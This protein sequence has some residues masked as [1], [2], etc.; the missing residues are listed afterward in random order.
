MIFLLEED[1]GEYR[2]DGFVVDDEEPIEVDSDEEESDG[3]G[4]VVIIR[5]PKKKRHC[6]CLRGTDF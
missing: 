3:L 4:E 2:L 1:D 6:N 5:R